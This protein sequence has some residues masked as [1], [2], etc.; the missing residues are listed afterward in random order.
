MIN[1][2]GKIKSIQFLA[3]LMM[4]SLSFLSHPARA[5]ENQPKKKALIVWG[6]WEGHEPKKCV[7]IFAPWLVEQGFEEEKP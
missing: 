3:I 7:D 1:K 5:V 4:I 6:G 2:S